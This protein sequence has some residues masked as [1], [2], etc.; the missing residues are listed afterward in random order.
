MGRAWLGKYPYTICA[1]VLAQLT[2]HCRH[3]QKLGTFNYQIMATEGYESDGE[4]TITI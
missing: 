3:V 1:H 4:V 2:N